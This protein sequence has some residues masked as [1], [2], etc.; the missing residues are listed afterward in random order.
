[1]R[2]AGEA[3]L[4]HEL[5]AAV[6]ARL[7]VALATV[8][9]T[10]RA[11]PRHAGSKM[12]IH[13]DGRWSGSVG[14]GEMEARVLAEAGAALADGRPRLL[15]YAF[16]DPAA[17]D[18]GVCGGEA[19]VSI[20]PH[21]PEP[22]VLVVGCGHVGRA[23][24]ELADWLGFHVAAADDREELLTMELLP[25]ADV[26][27]RGS[28]A[29]ALETLGTNAEVFAVLATR[30]TEVDVEWLPALLVSGARSIGVIGS[31]RRWR[32]TR[33][34]LIERGVPAVDL[35]EVASP[36]GLDIGAET[37]REIALAILGQVVALRRDSA[38]EPDPETTEGPV[39]EAA[40][41][42]G[43]TAEQTRLESLQAA[44]QGARP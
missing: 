15:R 31:R 34:E 38:G 28:A 32:R 24:V 43:P 41:P 25:G 17:G 42:R 20:E 22:T 21:L 11:V 5:V 23:V 7:P 36:V 6:D 8:V 30:G 9:E 10:H 19:V 14:G 18:P 12:L 35:D 29:E 26:L 37:P 4:L 2:N 13:G 1:M 40:E 27:L 44:L 39:P 3:S 33:S 16:V